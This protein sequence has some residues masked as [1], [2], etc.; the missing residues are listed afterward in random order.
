M[1]ERY[2]RQT[3]FAP[4]GKQG[5]EQIRRGRVLLVGVGALGSHIATWLVRAGVGELWLVDRD[6]VGPLVG[7]QLR[8]RC[9]VGLERP[10]PVQVIGCQVQPLL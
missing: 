3:R 4:L 5:Q 1:S 2:S 10:V 6:V 8:L 9:G 7:P